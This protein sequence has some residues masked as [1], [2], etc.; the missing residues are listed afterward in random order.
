MA[1]FK[2]QENKRTVEKVVFSLTKLSKKTMKVVAW[3]TK[4]RREV[5]EER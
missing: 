3:K 4:V 2:G 1:T 5:Q